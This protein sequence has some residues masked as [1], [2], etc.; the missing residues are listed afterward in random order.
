[1][2]NQRQDKVSS[3]KIILTPALTV[4]RVH[5]EDLCLTVLET[6]NSLQIAF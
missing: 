5:Y 1:M 4:T 6:D 3:V 2:L